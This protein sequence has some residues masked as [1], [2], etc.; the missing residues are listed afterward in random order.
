MRQRA[1]LSSVVHQCFTC[2]RPL[3]GPVVGV[4]TIA[5]GPVPN[6]SSKE[7]A[8]ATRGSGLCEGRT[9]RMWGITMRWAFASRHCP[10][11]A[12]RAAAHRAC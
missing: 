8:G 12:M 5:D 3:A 2:D 11:P 6:H 1:L 4:S 9:V 10:A 7:E